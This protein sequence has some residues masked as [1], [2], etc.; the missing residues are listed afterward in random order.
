MDP[1]DLPVEDIDQV[2]R[3][4]ANNICRSR[5]YL[6]ILTSPPTS[7]QTKQWRIKECPQMLDI[8]NYNFN[9]FAAFA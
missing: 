5:K 1:E 8:V 2:D 3:K 9:T 4:K 6:C 7:S